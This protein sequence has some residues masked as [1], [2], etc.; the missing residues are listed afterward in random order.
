MIKSVVSLY[1]QILGHFGNFISIKKSSFF[2]VE[3][4]FTYHPFVCVVGCVEDKKVLGE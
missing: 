3:F 4:I 2:S 1:L